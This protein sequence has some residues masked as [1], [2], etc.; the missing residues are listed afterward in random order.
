MALHNV[1]LSTTSMHIAIIAVQK[2]D[3]LLASSL[4]VFALLEKHGEA[5]NGAINKQSSNDTHDGSLLV[6]QCAMREE[7]RESCLWQSDL[8]RMEMAGQRMSKLFTPCEDVPMPMTTRNPV[9][10]LPKSTSPL[11]PDSMKSS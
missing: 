8:I 1:V 3:L 2:S 6:D 9:R 5:D 4:E 11:P 7:D 10:N